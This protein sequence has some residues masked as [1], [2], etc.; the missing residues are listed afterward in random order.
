MLALL[1]LVLDPTDQYKLK[2]V[3]DLLNLHITEENLLKTT[4]MN[5]QW[6]RIKL[7]L[8]N[9]NNAIK[10]NLLQSQQ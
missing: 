7:A 6:T 9:K 5:N 3:F 8:K 4:Y 2:S 10:Y 1:F